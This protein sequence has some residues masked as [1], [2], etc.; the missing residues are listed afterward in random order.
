[1]HWDVVLDPRKYQ[2]PSPIVIVRFLAND[3]ALINNLSISCISYVFSR[4]PSL[5]FIQVL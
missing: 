2:I 5:V 4:T 3:T 1:M